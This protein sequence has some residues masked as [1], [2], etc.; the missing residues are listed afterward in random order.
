MVRMNRIIL[1]IS[2]VAVLLAAAAVLLWF[3]QRNG[4]TPQSSPGF[5]HPS[6]PAPTA[7]R[8]VFSIVLH[9]VDEID[10]LLTRAEKL[11]RE[12]PVPAGSGI[13]LVLHGPEVE[14]FRQ[15]NYRRYQA[16]VDRARRLDAAGVVEVKMCRT[17]MQA[18]GI[19][20]GEIHDFIE[21]VPFGPAEVERLKGLGYVSL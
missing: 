16:I 1:G 2:A 17:Q 14:F 19:H 20:D 18:H 8:Y 10:R 21:V 3:T 6:L 7:N 4:V 13:A 15:R 12:R 11:A 5:E 9:R